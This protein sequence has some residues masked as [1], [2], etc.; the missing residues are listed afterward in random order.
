MSIQT[1]INRIAAN[2]E[3]AYAA[4]LAKGAAMPEQQV[5]EN[6]A[7]CIQS[8]ASGGD[9]PLGDK[10][11][12]FGVTSDIH[13]R[14]DN[15]GNGID[16][17]NRTIPLL[18]NLGA[19]FVGIPGDLGYYGN[20][21]ELEL[22]N[23]ALNTLATVPFHVVRGNH[24][25]P[26]TDADWLTYTGYT[27]NHE[28]VYY[29]D[30]FLFMSMDYAD[31]TTNAIES[32]YA[33][34]LAWLK[35][36]LDR[37]KGARIFIFC[38]YPPSGYSGL[39]DGQYYGW[40]S[41]ATEDDELVTIINQTKNVVMFTGHTHYRLNVQDTYDNMNIYRFNA[42][43]TALVHV[44]S[45]SRPRDASGNTVEEYSEGYIVEVYEQGV[46]IRGVD[47]VSGE[48]MP[49]Y[50]YVLAMDN[51]PSAS[52]NA[53][54]LSANDISLDAGASIEVEVTLDAPS[55][56]IVSV[57][58]NNS[59]VTVSPASLTFTEENYNVPQKITITGAVN[60]DNNA[61]SVITL[62][63]HGF[64]D[65][66]ISVTLAEIALTDIVPG[67]NQIVDGAAYGGSYTAGRLVFPDAGAFE[68]TFVNLNMST[69]DSCFVAKGNPIDGIIHLV[70]D[71]VMHSAKSRGLSS[72]STTPLQLVSNSGA[73][74]TVQGDSS[75][76]AGMKGDF[77]I[78]NIDLTVVTATTPIEVVSRG[79]TIVGSGSVSV[80][81]AKAA[82]LA[83]EGG[84][85]EV[86]LGAGT[87][88]SSAITVTATPEDGYA[89]SAIL[90]NG[91]ASTDSLTM[92]A[93]GETL[94]IQGV[95][96]EA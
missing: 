71:N 61:S 12:T 45:N 35:A 5:S 9:V 86:N 82:V 65:K 54:I 11:Y 37:Y 10:L 59:N 44:P 2:I 58:V 73:T 36:R 26:F 96:T 93:A 6:L 30:V 21:N 88:D 23:S 60:V 77:D 15:C 42:S 13:L 16:D 29:G 84:N 55:N 80:N 79:L 31:N 24:D 51:N 22:Y 69:S 95:F 85:L 63:A 78:T 39:A 38:H 46:V 53:I 90:V 91:V 74:L 47:F 92:P 52:A 76:S 68:I 27:A 75:S 25:K 57:A 32:G 64:V 4:A 17:F 72:S 56:A 41:T 1:Q 43:K 83:C 50:E 28:F 20:T 81:D 7:A 34:G 3:A 94:T 19:E 48:M 62:S 33:E 89:L 40:T 49:D 18:Q 67:D 14:P 87:P 66:T 8:I 70:G